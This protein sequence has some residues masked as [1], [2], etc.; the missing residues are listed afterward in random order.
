MSPTYYDYEDT[1][2]H[3]YDEAVA[4]KQRAITAG[5][6]VTIAG[7]SSMLAKGETKGETPAKGK[8]EAKEEITTKEASKEK[9][10]GRAVDNTSCSNHGSDVDD[11]DVGGSKA[12]RS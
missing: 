2:E 3:G 4:A 11:D 10:E 6:A 1:D 9:E 5:Q 8:E 7:Q 12:R